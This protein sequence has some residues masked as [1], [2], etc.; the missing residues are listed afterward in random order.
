MQAN[1]YADDLTLSCNGEYLDTVIGL[2]QMNINELCGWSQKTRLKLFL[3]KTQYIIFSK[4]HKQHR[5][6]TKLFI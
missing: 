2:L 5:N 1:L 6:P 3:H 4:K